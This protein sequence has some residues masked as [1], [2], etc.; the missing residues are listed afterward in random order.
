MPVSNLSTAALCVVSQ[1]RNLCG[2]RRSVNKETS[3]QRKNGLESGLGSTGFLAVCV[4]V[5]SE[6]CVTDGH[7][8]DCRNGRQ[9]GGRCESLCQRTCDSSGDSAFLGR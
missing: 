1:P 8:F 7:P 6:R 9:L 4:Y 2:R 3:E 5:L